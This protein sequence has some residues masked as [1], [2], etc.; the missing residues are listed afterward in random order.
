MP[1]RKIACFETFGLG[2]SS[3]GGLFSFESNLFLLLHLTL[4]NKYCRFIYGFCWELFQQKQPFIVLDRRSA[5]MGSSLFALAIMV[6]LLLIWVS[7]EL[8]VIAEKAGRRLSKDK[9]NL[10]IVALVLIFA[11]YAYFWTRFGSSMNNTGVN[12]TLMLFQTGSLYIASFCLR[13]LH[14]DDKS[15]AL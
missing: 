14:E 3:L 5:T 4:L 10:G 13:K 8:A 12:L 6:Q 7:P 15:T 1:V 9:L 11:T 2:R